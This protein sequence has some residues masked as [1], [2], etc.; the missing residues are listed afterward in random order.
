MK[1]KIYLAGGWFTKEQEEEH[2][3]IYN[4]IKDSFE[5]FNPR[6]EGEVTSKTSTDAMTDILLGNI[7][8]IQDADV[9]L[10]IYDYKDV[11]TIW[12]SGFAYANCKPILYYSETLN[13]KK[14]NLM[15]AK[16]GNYVENEKDLMNALNSQS[17]YIFKNVYHSYSGEIE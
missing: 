1:K 6:L 13:G 17:T 2:T 7:K 5:V 16:T 11:G 4:L 12:E 14:F 3:R 15:L 9:I 8:G 10:V